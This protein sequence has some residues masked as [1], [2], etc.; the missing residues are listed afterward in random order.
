MLATVLLSLGVPMILGGDEL[1]RTQ[2]GSNN[3][4]CQDNETSWYDWEKVDWDMVSFVQRVGALRRKHPL[5]RRSEFPT[6][7][8]AWFTAAGEDVPEPGF[9]D[10]NSRSLGILIDKPDGDPAEALY[11]MLN[12]D[13][14]AVGFSLP[15]GTWELLLSSGNTTIV[16]A[17]A[18]LQDFT[19]A[20]A[21]RV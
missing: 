3:A 6:S 2:N 17:V 9:A 21:R 7:P 8:E 19:L 18:S 14:H 16:G 1:G 5:L 15:V 12:S 20:V 13:D 11:L 10:P 4:Y